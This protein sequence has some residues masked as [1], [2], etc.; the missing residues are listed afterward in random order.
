MA[1]LVE[2]LYVQYVR[3]EDG[4][5]ETSDGFGISH[6][7]TSTALAVASGPRLIIYVSRPGFW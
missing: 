4:Y 6:L 3:D 1:I 7:R 2:S 5:R